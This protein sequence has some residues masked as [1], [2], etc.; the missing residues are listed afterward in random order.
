MNFCQRSLVNSSKSEK[1]TKPVEDYLY[2]EEKWAQDHLLTPL[3]PLTETL[4]KEIVSHVAED[5]TS[6]P[7]KDGAALQRKAEPP[8]PPAPAKQAEPRPEPG[9]PGDPDEELIRNLELLQDLELL[10]HADAFDPESKD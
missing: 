8:P 4:F 1:G 7:V 5:D 2:A 9:K 3:A 6:P 10:E